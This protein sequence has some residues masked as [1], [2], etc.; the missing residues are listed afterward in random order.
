MTPTAPERP[1]L[2]A[3][4]LDLGDPDLYT[5][6]RRYAMWDSFAA[7]DRVVWTEPG[8]APNGFWS[9]FSH[10]ACSRVLAPHAPF[11][12]EYGMMIGFDATHADHAGG[13]MIV[14]TDGDRHTR[15][16]RLIGP[17]LSRAKAASLQSF[18]EAETRALF[19]L[20]RDRSV[21][22]VAASIGPRIPA[23]AVCEILGV[24]LDDREFLIGLTN[25]AFGGA[26]ASF[27]EMTSAE[28]HGEILLYF[29][30]LIDE[31]RTHP[32][33]DIISVLL[34]D[35]ELSPDDVLLN[36]DNVLV[37]GNETTR[38]AIIG[39]FHAAAAY[40]GVLS[41]LS[42]GTDRAEIATEEVIRWTS[43]AMHVLRVA[44]SDVTIGGQAIE[45]GSALAAWLP[46]ANR[47][48]RVFDNPDRFD[49]T[50]RPNRHL[51]FGV[52]A[53]HCLGAALARVEIA[54]LLGVM[55]ETIDEVGLAED[56]QWL[57][58]NLVQGYRQLTAEVAW[59][60]RR[61]AAG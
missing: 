8:A 20:E 10:L 12:S 18:I 38:H 16:R 37:G 5:T 41:A 7:D 33:E 34:Q 19:D 1:S 52:G 45:K 6:V 9:V 31:R 29:S 13:R 28:A 46:A 26:D 47:D 39:A 27:S 44:T 15:L 32:G 36:C 25:H 24:P 57:R 43:P 2:V 30:D 50:R 40:P 54:I 58:S 23:A 51:G 61:V 60:K 14:V 55:A 48:R 3:E 53:H 42:T 11:T 35:P 49:V 21:V 4:G 17:F 22:D 56:P 59:R